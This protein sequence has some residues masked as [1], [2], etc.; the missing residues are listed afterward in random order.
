M[1]QAFKESL[2]SSAGSSAV[3]E[4]SVYEPVYQIMPERSLRKVFQECYLETVIFLKNE[5]Q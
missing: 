2:E 1:K 3:C 4:C 5:L